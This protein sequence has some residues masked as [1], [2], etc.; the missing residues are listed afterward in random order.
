M[1]TE[2]VNLLNMEEYGRGVF[3]VQDE[4]SQIGGLQVEARLKESVLDYCA[5]SGGKSLAFAH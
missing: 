2:G 4:S 3:S 1:S 5:G